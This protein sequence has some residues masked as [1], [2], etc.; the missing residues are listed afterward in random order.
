M[1]MS[2][3]MIIIPA[4]LLVIGLFLTCSWR[5]WIVNKTLGNS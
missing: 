2:H 5:L 3:A 1:E 4:G